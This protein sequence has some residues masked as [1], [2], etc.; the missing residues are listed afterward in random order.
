MA[1]TKERWMK[2]FTKAQKA[3]DGTQAA[4]AVK[5]S[6]ATAAPAAV[7][8]SACVDLCLLS[9]C[10]EEFELRYEVRGKIRER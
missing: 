3:E 2:R 8:A 10:G 7:E 1:G 9:R 6:A 4:V 5:A